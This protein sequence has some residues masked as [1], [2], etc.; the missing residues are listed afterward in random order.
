MPRHHSRPLP[1]DI[2]HPAE[3]PALALAAA[4][5]RLDIFY[6]P[7]FPAP[8]LAPCPVVTTVHDLILDRVAEYG[9]GK[10]VRYYYRPMMRLAARKARAVI[11]VSEATAAD[12]RALYRVPDAK[13]SVVTEAADPSFRP[14]TDPTELARVRARY[15]L[16][17]RFALA[18]GAHRPH[19][20]LATLIEAFAM[21]C[22][23]FPH[24]LVLAGE[25]HARYDD[26]APAAIARLG[27][28]ERVRQ[29]GH[30]ADADL[31]ALYTLA[32]AFVQPSLIE[33]FG[34][35]VLEAMRCGAP[36]VASNTSSLPEVIGEAGLLADPRD[37]AS[38]ST[39]LAG[40]VGGIFD[41]GLVV[42]V[43][44]GV[45]GAF[46]LGQ[47]FNPWLMRIEDKKWLDDMAA[48]AQATAVAQ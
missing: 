24:S 37:P 38:L 13:I 2:Y 34:L 28:G 40:W 41:P 21:F 23:R 26:P 7:Y 47:L 9:R 27:L 22:D 35:P 4:R 5:D 12:L 29:T 32:E 43:L 25:V 31:P 44:A 36:V 16:P 8:L 17:D 45:S 39:A 33:G 6:S 14:V 3:Q 11:C 15:D 20:N 10:W 46:A 1:L 42:A 19:K 18:L 48:Q 30:V